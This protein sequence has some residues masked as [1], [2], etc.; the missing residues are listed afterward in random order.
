MA[1]FLFSCSRG[2]LLCAP[3]GDPVRF[4]QPPLLTTEARVHICPVVSPGSAS[5]WHTQ[6]LPSRAE[7]TAGPPSRGPTSTLHPPFLHR[8]FSL[9][10]SSEHGHL[11]LVTYL[12]GQ[13]RQNLHSEKRMQR[14]L[15][16][17]LL[18]QQ[19]R[20]GFK[21]HK[22]KQGASDCSG[23]NGIRE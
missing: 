13:N 6:R 22:T 5:T 1:P 3:H 8:H 18:N 20:G 14:G 7:V 12:L 10:F 4:L 17:C 9:A 21:S 15:G 19:A 16:E 23:E 11:V 2:F